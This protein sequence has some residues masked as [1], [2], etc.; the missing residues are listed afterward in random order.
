MA[1]RIRRR[2]QI[3]PGI[4]LNLGKTGIS[5]SLGRKGAHV[6]LGPKGTRTTVGLPG[7]GMSWTKHQ[8]H[9]PAR[10]REKLKDIV[11]TGGREM[12]DNI[13]RTMQYPEISTT[14]R[15]ELRAQLVGRSET[16]IEAADPPI[17]G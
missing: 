14:E 16:V 2:L 3:F 11:I 17:S 10:E 8:G 5:F 1:V 6:T 12:A 9:Q 13:A 7:T 4:S 15:D